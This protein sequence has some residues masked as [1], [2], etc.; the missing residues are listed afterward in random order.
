MGNDS[1]RQNKL[2]DF[3]KSSLKEVE[4][5]TDMSDW[6]QMEQRLNL[7]QQSSIIKNPKLLYGGVAAVGVIAVVA[8][9]AYY[10]T[11][12]SSYHD[13]KVDSPTATVM[14]S[15]ITPAPVAVLQEDTNVAVVEPTE[16]AS[17]LAV[18]AEESEV[19]AAPVVSAPKESHI[20]TK[21]IE[22]TVKEENSPSPK[23]ETV[24][25]ATESVVQKEE[26][27]DN[28]PVSFIDV[29]DSLR[30]NKVPT[31]GDMIDPGK[32]FTKKTAEEARLQR[33][34]LQKLQKSGSATGNVNSIEAER[35]FD[36]TPNEKLDE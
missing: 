20:P 8:V 26:E 35:P 32:G 11:S 1:T 36:T 33:E 3:I 17:I 34:A 31:F 16:M 5:T 22:T 25:I 21:N 23:K 14:P 24:V 12:A 2:D 27:N 30:K 15:P 4:V 28:T 13:E 19:A 29:F 9:L 7:S 10:V 18:D 6:A